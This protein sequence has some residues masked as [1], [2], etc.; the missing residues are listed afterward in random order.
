MVDGLRPPV[1]SAAP[2]RTSSDRLGWSLQPRTGRHHCHSSAGLR[3]QRWP[4]SNT[5]TLSSRPSHMAASLFDRL[6]DARIGATAAYIAAH[7]FLNL[8]L[9]SRVALL[10]ARYC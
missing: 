4:P 2:R 9:A 7:P 5:R 8:V 1:G 3:P 6:A 10:D